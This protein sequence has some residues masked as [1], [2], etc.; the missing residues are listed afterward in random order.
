M[1]GSKKFHKT[2]TTTTKKNDRRVLW[3]HCFNYITEFGG[4]EFMHSTIELLF[5][6]CQKSL[7]L[8]ELVTVFGKFFKMYEFVEIQIKFLEN[9]IWFLDCFVFF[10]R[11]GCPL[12]TPHIHFYSRASVSCCPCFSL[13]N[14]YNSMYCAF[15]HIGVSPTNKKKAK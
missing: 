9:A 7:R 6:A 13:G 12:F 11:T 14:W 2:R 1:L 15:S 8:T 10:G 3:L 5:V 4:D